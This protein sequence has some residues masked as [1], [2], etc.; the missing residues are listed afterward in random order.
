MTEADML[1][2]DILER[3][4]IIGRDESGR[5]IIEF[6]VDRA[7][8]ERFMAFGADLAEAEDGGDA[9]PDWLAAA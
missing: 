7:T 1:L 6:A 3:G 2:R 8:F 9:E 4:D 5:I